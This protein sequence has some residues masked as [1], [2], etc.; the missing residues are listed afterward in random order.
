M[1]RLTDS[2]LAKVRAGFILQGRTLKSW[3]V[4]EGVDYGYA[5]K[6]VDGKTNGPKARA[7]R[8]RIVEAATTSSAA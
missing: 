6:V 4:G 8:A 1:L 3:C 7:L 5:H 2:Q